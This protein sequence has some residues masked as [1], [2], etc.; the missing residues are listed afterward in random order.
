MAEWVTLSVHGN[1]VVP[2]RTAGNGPLMTVA[3]AD[4][5]DVVGFPTGWGKTFRGRAGRA[6]WF[7]YPLPTIDAWGHTGSTHGIVQI[8]L[9]FLAKNTATMTDGHVWSLS[10]PGDPSIAE[11][12][13]RIHA[14]TVSA[15][16]NHLSAPETLFFTPLLQFSGPLGV[17]MLLNFGAADSDV[18][19]RGATVTFEIP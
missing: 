7:H 2:E 16:G 14:R 18:V 10:A 11:T 15:T 5:S 9:F 8:L 17:S 12:D 4:W 3:G 1:A 13:G 19:F 6:N